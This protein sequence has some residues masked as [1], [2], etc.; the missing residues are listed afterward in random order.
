MKLRNVFAPAALVLSLIVVA[1]C[2]KDEKN[3]GVSNAKYNELVEKY[4]KQVKDYNT[5]VSQNHTSDDLL[6]ETSKLVADLDDKALAVR[7]QTRKVRVNLGTYRDGASLKADMKELDRLIQDALTIV[8]KLERQTSKKNIDQVVSNSELVI[9]DEHRENYKNIALL[10]GQAVGTLSG[11]RDLFLSQYNDVVDTVNAR[12]RDLPAGVEPT[13]IDPSREGDLIPEDVNPIVRNYDDGGRVTG[14]ARNS[15]SGS[16]VS[17]AFV[18]FKKRRESTDYFYETTTNSQG[19]YESPYLLPGTYYVDIRRDGYINVQNQAVRVNRGQ[20]SRENLSLS[21]PLED[22]VYRVTLSWTSQKANAVRDVD[23]YLQIPGVSE[24]LSFQNKQRA[25]HG[26]YLDRD[27]TDWI[28]PETITINDMKQGTYIYYVNNYDARNNKQAL[29]NSDIRVKLY[30]GD[31]LLKSFTVPQGSGLSYEIFR[32]ENGE[33]KLT[34]TFN[35][36][37]KMH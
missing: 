29:G 27:D 33:V 13:D 5:L 32:I 26:A 7:K 8:A 23:S 24:P 1:G 18:G 4:N 2:T 3:D 6:V 34:G 16:P 35:D 14:I 20:E 25:Y 28:G 30:E 12:L 21:E 15:V 11:I 31:R 9:K 10:A 36:R 19:Q 37:L 17:N 22:G